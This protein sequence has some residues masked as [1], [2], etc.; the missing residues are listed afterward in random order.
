VVGHL[1]PTA[2]E[3]SGRAALA[4]TQKAV[5]KQ[6]R[7]TPEGQWQRE[8]AALDCHRATNTIAGTAASSAAVRV[9]ERATRRDVEKSVESWHS[10]G[11]RRGS[12]GRKRRAIR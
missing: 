5:L 8:R 9:L 2:A 6:R 3:Q 4:G 7:N 12:A 10:T 1:D 11:T